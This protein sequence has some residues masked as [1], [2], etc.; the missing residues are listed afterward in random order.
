VSGHHSEDPTD[1]PRSQH[2]VSLRIAVDI[3][4]TF[5]DGIAHATPGNRIWVAKRLTTPD[6]PGR[7]V[8]E[9]V[10][11]L[12]THADGPGAAAVAEVV[13]G[14]TLVT[15]TIIERDG[16]RTGMLMTRGTRDVLDIGRELRYDPYDLDLQF[17]EPLV[18]RALRAEVPERL[19]ASG[20]VIDGLARDAFEEA[21]ARLADRGIESLA[22]C[23]LHAYANPAHERL[24]AR[25]ARRRLPGIPISTSSE[26]AG[27]IREFE[28]ACTVAA[29]AYVRPRMASY[30]AALG[31]RLRAQAIRAPLRIM[32]SSGGFTTSSAAARVPITL[33]ESGPAGGVL[34]AVHTA[35]E[36]G[37][38]DLLAL[39]MGGTTA[40]ACVAQGGE[41]N[42]VH[43]FEA[44]RVRRFVK[45]SGLPMLIPSIDLIEIGAGGGSIARA[46][47]LGLLQVGPQSA[48]AVPG[49]ACYGQ[50]GELATVTDADL[51]LGYLDAD[52]FLGGEMRLDISAARSAM[53]R[54]GRELG[55][56]RHATAWGIHNLV[57]ENM[58][59]AARVHVAEK[60]LDPR[61]FTLVA[62]GG[63]GP[64]HA[65]EVAHKLG[66]RQVLCTVAAGAGSC[67]GFLAAP[68]RVDRSLSRVQMLADV[69]WRWLSRTLERL[70]RD[71]SRE[72][73][74]ASSARMRWRLGAEIRYAGQGNAVDVQ[75][76]YR[77]IDAGTPSR[78]LRAFEHRYRT[79]YGALV[80][81]AHAQVLTWRLSGRA[82]RRHP[83][84]RLGADAL[85]AARPVAARRAQRTDTGDLAELPVYDRY[86]LPAGTVL[87]APLILRERESTIVVARPGEVT[88]QPNLTIAIALP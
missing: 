12:L 69:D 86:A 63:A 42:V 25:L 77:S 15:N 17:P 52:D 40:K 13:H 4:G 71:A 30:L 48:G 7:A 9:V 82:A 51:L 75:L 18:P 33:L 16:A 88:V 87:Q 78:V 26:V 37:V 57:N 46:D 85:G 20:E 81:G 6:D 23:F 39:D 19:G 80:P 73:G 54:L 3:G 83:R 56:D 24:A 67:M 28:R 35:R 59:G 44:A 36:A 58:A 31:R 68:A 62:T 74:A 79:L 41:P 53:D 49:P 50:G 76:S 2:S 22:I 29:N 10:A 65:V 32:L 14:T 1:V 60:G 64:V 21:L 27:E 55:L 34:S 66:I 61:R 70:H 43:S 45:G 47:R 5:T 11:D 84:F 38:A 8:S 72:L